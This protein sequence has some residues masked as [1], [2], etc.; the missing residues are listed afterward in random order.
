MCEFF[1]KGMFLKYVYIPFRKHI[2]ACYPTNR[3]DHMSSNENHSMLFISLFE[4]FKNA[5]LFSRR[6]RLRFSRRRFTRFRRLTSVRFESKRFL[7]YSNNVLFLTIKSLYNLRSDGKV[8]F[9][10]VNIQESGVRCVQQPR[11]ER[12]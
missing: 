11:R 1:N 8:G 9:A 6:T 5:R 4:P 10:M 7:V 12:A 2:K 3:S